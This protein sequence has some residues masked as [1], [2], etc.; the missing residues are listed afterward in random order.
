MKLLKPW[1]HCHFS[2]SARISPHPIDPDMISQFPKGG[3]ERSL[4]LRSTI[5]GHEAANWITRLI[6]HWMKLN[7]APF[8]CWWCINNLDG[9]SAAY[10]LLR[11]D[12]AFSANLDDNKFSLL[13]AM[14]WYMSEKKSERKLFPDIIKLLLFRLVPTDIYTWEHRSSSRE[15]SIFTT[16]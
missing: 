13:S 10:P 2:F 6:K 3:T 15:F 8:P 7:F 9:S 5:H 16:F 4:N 1:Q 11:M 12:S 14:F